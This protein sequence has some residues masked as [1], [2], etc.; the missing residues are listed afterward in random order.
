MTLVD[1]GLGQPL[2][3]KNQK[4]GSKNY[5]DYRLFTSK[6]GLMAL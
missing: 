5:V 2:F 1:G 4:F 6:Y 3:F